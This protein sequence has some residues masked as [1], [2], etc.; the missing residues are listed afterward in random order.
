MAPDPDEAGRAPSARGGLT[1]VLHSRP[2]LPSKRGSHAD[3]SNACLGLTSPS[4]RTDRT[5]SDDPATRRA[6]GPLRSTEGASCRSPRSGR[7]GD[8]QIDVSASLPPIS[9]AK[10]VPPAPTVSRASAAPVM[11]FL[12]V[13]PFPPGPPAGSY[14]TVTPRDVESASRADR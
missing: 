13:H 11:I 14:R 3:E 9:P 8:V 6:R 1:G 7:S 2:R 4:P 10:A 12:I 5:G